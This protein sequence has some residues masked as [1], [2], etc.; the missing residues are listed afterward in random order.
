M[1][2]E[3]RRPRVSSLLRRRAAGERPVRPE[4]QDQRCAVD[5]R[6]LGFLTP[7][8]LVLQARTASLA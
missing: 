7:W 3:A 5:D 1:R 4:R 2:P 8:N 6:Q